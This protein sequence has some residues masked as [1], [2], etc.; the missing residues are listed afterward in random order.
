MMG[1]FV[2][3]PLIICIADVLEAC[4]SKVMISETIC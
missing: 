4:F 2:F 1:C 3:V